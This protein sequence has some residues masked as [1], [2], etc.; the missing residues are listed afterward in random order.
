M[1]VAALPSGASP[2]VST[3][4]NPGLGPPL[5]T[6]GGSQLLVPT[7]DGSTLAWSPGHG[8]TPSGMWQ[9]PPAMSRE[10]TS[11][12]GQAGPWLAWLSPDGGRVIDAYSDGS[13]AER[14]ASTGRVDELIP[15]PSGMIGVTGGQGT[16]AVDPAGQAVAL[17][18]LEGVYVTLPATRHTHRLPGSDA[19]R[20]AFDGE[21]LLVQQPDGSLQ[22]WNADATR[23]MRV[24]NGI[25]STVAG[26]V[27]SSAGLALEARS[28]HSAVVIDLNSGTTLGTLQLS[29]SPLA[30]R[31]G[32]AMSPD[33]T[34]LVAVT[35]GNGASDIGE[36][37]DWQ[38]SPQAWLK[39]ACATAGH[40]LTSAEWQEYVGGPP[41]AQMACA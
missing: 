3:A 40:P 14:N 8:L 34:S 6:R 32:I 24:I 22:F 7:A 11:P 1:T 20:V 21:Q 31:T 10:L 37:T 26:P 35:E 25:A 36:L 33:G 15:G 16:A 28:D 4:T 2:A 27:V 17:V 30:L 41:P 12:E 19:D 13:I 38:M 18:G 23:L 9:L 29:A 39:A 5:W